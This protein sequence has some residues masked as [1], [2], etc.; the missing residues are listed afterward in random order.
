MDDLKRAMYVWLT[1][2]GTRVILLFVLAAALGLAS[3]LFFFASDSGSPS[4]TE[5]VLIL[6]AMVV[7]FYMSL[8]SNVY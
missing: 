7:V 6:A 4:R 1:D 5:L 3:L 8:R 2:E